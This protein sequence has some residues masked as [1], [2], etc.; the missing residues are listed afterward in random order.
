MK[1]CQQ[2]IE[3]KSKS[4]RLG[5][6]VVSSIHKL[7]QV[8]SIYVYCMNKESHKQWASNSSNVKLCEKFESHFIILFDRSKA[9]LLILMNLSLIL[10][11]IITFR[12]R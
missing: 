10:Q 2:Y 5:R 6:E 7:R 12:K 11:Q 1:Q 3:Q 8:I 9:L 4:D